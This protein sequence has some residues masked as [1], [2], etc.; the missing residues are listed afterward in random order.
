MNTIPP[1]PNDTIVLWQKQFLTVL[2]RFE[3]HAQGL[4]TFENE[5]N[6]HQARVSLRTLTT[7]TGFLRSAPHKSLDLELLNYLHA[8]SRLILKTLG[9][10]R[11][12]DVTLGHIKDINQDKL[13]LQRLSHV[14][15]LERQMARIELKLHLPKLLDD[16]LFE[17][18]Q[19]FIHVY[20]P[21]HLQYLNTQRHFKKL[22]KKFEHRYLTYLAHHEINGP[23]HLRTFEALH[24]VRL[25]TKNLRYAYNYLEFA[26]PGKAQLGAKARVKQYKRIQT[27]LGLMNDYTNLREKLKQILEDYPYLVNTD[28]LAFRDKINKRLTKSLKSIVL[29][30]I[31]DL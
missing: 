2:D 19:T 23:A 9:K 25:I 20:L 17:L 8:R 14:L 10:I 16:Q 15:E 3:T 13:D 11:D 22:H 29:P 18:W 4:F 24:D 26:L 27:Q 5:R 12:F 28:T 30:S 7:F 6:V 31:D 21:Q 1:L